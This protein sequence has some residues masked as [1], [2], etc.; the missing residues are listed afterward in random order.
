V[1]DASDGSDGSIWNGFSASLGGP[2]LRKVLS[3]GEFP[4]G[5]LYH[6]HLESIVFKTRTWQVEAFLC[7]CW[8]DFSKY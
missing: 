3:E 1:P 8:S 5:D 7:H 6:P 4:K 2:E